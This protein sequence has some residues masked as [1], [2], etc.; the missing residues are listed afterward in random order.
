M[1]KA[2]ARAPASAPRT[3]QSIP[4]CVLGRDIVNRW[5]SAS[6]REWLVTNGIGGFASGTVAGANTR[7]Y[8]GVL[9]ASFKPPVERTVL[10]SKVN[11]AVQ[12]LGERHELGADEFDGGTLAPSGFRRLES[13]RIDEGI[14]V[15]RFEISDALLEQRVFMAPGRNISYIGLRVIRASAPL[16]LELKPLCTYRDYHSHSRGARPFALDAGVRECSIRAFEGARPIRLS[17]SEGCFEAAPDWYWNFFH[18]A[19]GER[20][21]DTGE[22][23]YTP[24]R[25]TA[26]LSP[27]FLNPWMVLAALLPSVATVFAYFLIH[28]RQKLIRDPRQVRAANAQRALRLQLQTMERAAA[29]VGVVFAPNFS[30]AAPTIPFTVPSTSS[31]VSVFSAD[32]KNNFTVMLFCPFSS[33][34][35]RYVVTYSISSRCSGFNDRTIESNCSYAT[36]SATTNDRSRHTAGNS[37]IWR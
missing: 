23:L 27:W 15:W 22:D 10:V 33:G 13:F 37:V 11:I 14:P 34:L 35:P 9:V 18:R 32:R 7:R 24:G 4:H 29:R 3:T 30:V 25:F 12:Y 31:P 26:T 6:R 1:M 20:G 21:L 28:R 5:E 8:H 19:E 36:D 16:Q 17:I 2:A